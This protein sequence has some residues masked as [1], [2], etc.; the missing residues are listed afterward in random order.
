[1]YPLTAKRGAMKR[2]V[3]ISIALLS[4]ALSVL[5]DGC[6]DDIVGGPCPYTDFPGTATIRTVTPDNSIDRNCENDVII[7]FDFAPDD[8]SDVDSYRFPAWPDTGRTFDLISGGSVPD[9]WAEKEGLTPGSEHP[10][11]RREI[12]VGSCSPLIFEFPDV[13][14]TDWPDYCD[15]L[16]R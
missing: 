12:R 16:S 9:R 11:I 7:V 6:S 1:M 2:I 5:L 4:L 3:V 14:I 8:S 13:D 10:C 15:E